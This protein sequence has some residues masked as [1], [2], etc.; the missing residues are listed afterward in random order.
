MK[1]I[2]AFETKCLRNLLR[3]SFLEHKIDFLVDPQEPLLAT[4]KRR[5]LARFGHVTRHD[6]LSKPVLQGV[7]WSE[8]EVLDG[9]YQRMDIPVHARTA[10]N[11]LLQ[12]RLE[13]DICWIVCRVPPTTESVERLNWSEL[14]I[15][16]S[17]PI[18]L[19]MHDWSSGRN[20][21]NKI[22]KI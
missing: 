16:P 17:K 11:G 6:S 21:F 22:Y 9:R 19:R 5:K 13:E 20:S 8:E 10:H 1:R 12:Q 18:A 14:N 2:Q 15:Y 4:D 7:P 3:S